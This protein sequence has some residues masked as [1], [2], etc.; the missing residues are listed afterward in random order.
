M[1]LQVGQLTLKKR[2]ALELCV[3]AVLSPVGRVRF[4]P[5]VVNRGQCS[6]PCQTRQSLG[7]CQLVRWSLLIKIV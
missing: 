5:V 1:R 2:V 7:V 4:L 6:R 3:R